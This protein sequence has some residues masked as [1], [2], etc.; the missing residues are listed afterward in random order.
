[1][2]LNKKIAIPVALLVI[3]A[4]VGTGLLYK[5]GWFR[6]DGGGHSKLEHKVQL[7]TCSMHPFIIKDKPGTCPICGMELIKKIES[8]PVAGGARTAEQQ[9]QAD[10]L[11]QVSISSTQRVMANVATVAAEHAVMNKE[12]NAVG[13]V[14][15]DQSRQAKVT[16]W[17]AGRIDKLNVNTV[18]AYVSKDRPVAELY[19]PDLL[20]TQQEYLL[21]VR[22]REQLKSSPIPSIAQNGDGL[23]ASAR[24]RLM[25][26]GVKESQIAALEKAGKPN[27]RL[28]IYTPQSGVV[29]EKFV[30]QGQYVNTGDVLFSIADL[31]TVWVEIE[32]YENEFSNIRL[33]QQVH[34]LSQSFPGRPFSGRIAFIY[35]FL[36]PKNRTVK[37]RVEMPN[38]GMKL[39]PDMFVNAIIRVPLG[40]AIVVPVS[41][42]MDSGMRQTVWV[43]TSAGMFEARNVQIGGQNDGKVQILSGLKAGDKVAVSGGYLIDSESQLK[44]DGADHSQHGSGATP[45][46]KRQ[47]A[48]PPVPGN[49]PLKMDDMKM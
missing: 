34:I 42:V 13:I 47:P 29:I 31:S 33:G 9:Q 22:S 36:D 32:I 21:A 8:T 44:G 25:L 17:I 23:V 38:P 14:Q 2:L 12:I 24:Q 18:G 11:G 43:E 26:F 10:M 37:A 27:I 19:S 1:M 7:W 35:P 6:D 15:Y 39:K 5:N 3:A 16:A 45:E 46:A 28:P 41:A 4:S 30:Q 40:A 20:A 48:E 49:K